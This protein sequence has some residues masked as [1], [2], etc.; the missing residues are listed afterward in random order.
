MNEEE[1]GAFSGMTYLEAI[2]SSYRYSN[3]WDS[4]PA[5]DSTYEDAYMATQKEAYHI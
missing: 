2:E 5:A 1:R 3:M 4:E